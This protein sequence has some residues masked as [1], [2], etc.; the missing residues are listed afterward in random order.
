MAYARW[1]ERGGEVWGVQFDVVADRTIRRDSSTLMSLQMAVRND[2]SQPVFL[3]A[4]GISSLTRRLPSPPEKALRRALARPLRGTRPAR[5][6]S[7]DPVVHLALP[8]DQWPVIVQPGQTW[9]VTVDVASLSWPAD[10]AR[11]RNPFLQFGGGR[12]SRHPPIRLDA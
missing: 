11:I 5:R 6:L 1:P 4:A 8:H 9:N 2:R 7:D 10:L 12:T 3:Q